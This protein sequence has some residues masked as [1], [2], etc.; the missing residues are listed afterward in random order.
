MVEPRLQVLR[1]G[2]VDSEAPALG[3]EARLRRFWL[4]LSWVRPRT[5]WCSTCGRKDWRGCLMAARPPTLRPARMAQRARGHAPR[6]RLCPCFASPQFGCRLPW[7][8][9]RSPLVAR[10]RTN[11][12]C[13]RDRA[14]STSRSAM[15][16]AGSAARPKPT[17]S[18]NHRDHSL[19]R[20]IFL[21]PPMSVA[22]SPRLNGPPV[23]TMARRLGSRP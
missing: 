19:Q 16:P 20:A 8:D 14:L 4:R 6:F 3:V 2:T 10:R 18:K 11:T 7:V 17:Q 21:F 5:P 1:T 13:P 12:W 23:A 22:V 15:L 9:A